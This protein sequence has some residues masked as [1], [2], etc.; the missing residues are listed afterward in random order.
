MLGA[1]LYGIGTTCISTT[2]L[3]EKPGNNHTK[4]HQRN[5]ISSEVTL[6]NSR[7]PRLVVLT[8]CFA[9]HS[10]RHHKRHNAHSRPHICTCTYLHADTLFNIKWQIYLPPCYVKSILY[11]GR[12]LNRDSPSHDQHRP[13]RFKFF[14]PLRRYK[15]ASFPLFHLPCL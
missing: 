11:L 7:V 2:Y 10:T 1:S 9:F 5:D 3:I 6:D 15:S 4:I 8:H 12:C 14:R 13:P